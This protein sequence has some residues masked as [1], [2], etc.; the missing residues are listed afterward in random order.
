MNKTFSKSYIIPPFELTLD[1]IVLNYCLLDTT[2]FTSADNNFMRETILSDRRQTASNIIAQLNQCH[3][4]MCQHPLWGKD[5]VKLAYTAEVL[6]R[7]PCWGSKNMSKDSSGPKYSLTGWQSR[8]I[9]TF[10]WTNQSSKSLYQI[11][12]SIWCEELVK[13]LQPPVS[14][15]P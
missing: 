4:K 2:C 14:N 8:G 5:F 1:N 3:E 6:S 10:G 11:G 13:E 7:N 15:Q 9:K 12:R